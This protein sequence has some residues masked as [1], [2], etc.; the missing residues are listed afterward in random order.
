MRTL[1]VF[2]L[3]RLDAARQITAGAQQVFLSIIEFVAI[4]IHSGLGLGQVEFQSVRLVP[5]GLSQFFRELFDVVVVHVQLLF[6]FLLPRL[7]FFRFRRKRRRMI[8]GVGKSRAKSQ[9]HFVVAQPQGFQGVGFL[10]WQSRK[11]RELLR[12]LQ[13]TLIH[14]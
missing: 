14:K 10:F 12:R 9:V 7:C 6:R 5:S 1:F 11:L 4:E 8:S 13:R 2:R 3:G